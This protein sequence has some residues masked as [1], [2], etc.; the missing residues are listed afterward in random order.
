[1]TLTKKPLCGFFLLYKIRNYTK[2]K[3]EKFKIF[4]F[5]FGS[6]KKNSASG[7]TQ[8]IA[9]SLSDPSVDLYSGGFMT[10][11]ATSLQITS[12]VKNFENDAIAQYRDI[13]RQ[14]EVDLAVEEI[15]CEMVVM[16]HQNLLLVLN[17]DS[18]DISI[19]LKEVINKEFKTI[20]VF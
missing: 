2:A 16:E 19:E 4:G 8:Y 12:M 13:A 11:M 6:P 1:M 18:I 5:S 20:M 3:N 10:P 7:V 17:M 14:A 9:P 15:V